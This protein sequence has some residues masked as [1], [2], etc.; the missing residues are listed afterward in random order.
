MEYALRVILKHENMI[1]Y[2]TTRI[3]L[4]RLTVEDREEFVELVIASAGFL[5][6]WVYLPATPAKFD[7]YLQRFDGKSAECTLIC[8]RTSGAIAGTVSISDIIRG[9]YQRATVGYNA[10]AP[11]ARQGYMSEGFGLVFRF[12]FEGLG[13]HR[14]EAYIQPDDEASLRLAGTKESASLE[15]VTLPVSFV[16]MGSG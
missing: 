12:A 7:E 9:P 15:K 16:L 2:E 5:H 10:F 1:R 13:P 8:D 11:S 3:V 6:P 4:R 14:L